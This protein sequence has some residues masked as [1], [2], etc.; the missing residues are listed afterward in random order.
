[1]NSSQK[2]ERSEEKGKETAGHAV[3]QGA[4]G[5]GGGEAAARLVAIIDFSEDAIISKNLDGIVTSWNTGAE[6]LF[7]HRTDEIVGQP[8]KRIIPPDRQQE[9]STILA[10]LHMGERIKHLET[11]RMHKSLWLQNSVT[12][13]APTI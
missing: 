10:R 7:G 2:H 6:E 11:I 9:E 4:T 12:R 5:E 13:C 8:I 1:M 3:S